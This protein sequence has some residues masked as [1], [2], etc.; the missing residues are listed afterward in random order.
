MPVLRSPDNLAAQLQLARGICGRSHASEVGSVRHVVAGCAV[1]N[2]V[3][4]VK[5]F[6]TEFE[7]EPLPDG[8]GA[9][10]GGVQVPE[11]VGPESVS[12]AVA[13][14]VLSRNLDRV[15]V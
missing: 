10:D 7:S 8:K 2:G 1:D 14:G 13:E 6:R 12:T 5:R 3:Q 11:G 15:G 4:Q 9:K